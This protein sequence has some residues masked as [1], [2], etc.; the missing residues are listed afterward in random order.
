MWS[1]SK[2][3]EWQTYKGVFQIQATFPENLL[4]LPIMVPELS[5]GIILCKVDMKSSFSK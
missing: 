2:V 4:C 5:M 3:V 1:K